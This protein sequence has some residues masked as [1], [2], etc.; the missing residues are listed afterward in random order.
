MPPA[1]K[2]EAARGLTLHLDDSAPWRLSWGEPDW[3]GP[4]GFMLQ[5]AGEWHGG[6][7]DVPGARHLQPSLHGFAGRDDLGAYHSVDVAWATLPIPLRTSVRAYVDAPVIVFRIEAPNGVRGLSTGR[8]EQPSVVWP[9]L[10]PARRQAG[11]VPADTVSCGH[12]YTEF[13]LPVSGDAQCTGFRFAPHRPPVVEPLLFIAPDGRTLLLAPLDQFHEQIIVVPPDRESASDGVRCGW[14]GD[15]AEVPAGFATELAIWAG[16]GPREVLDA[17]AALLR[18]RHGTQRATR[19]ADAGVGMLSYWT[20]NGSVYYY[21]TEPECDYLTTLERVV[22]DL[23]AHDVPVRSLQID[24]WFY[25]HENLREVSPAGAPVVPPSGMLKWEPRADLFPNGASDLQRRVG[26]LPLTFH[27]RHFSH[28]SP[29]FEQYAAW[30][31]GAYAHP[32]D[33]ALFDRLMAQAATWGAIT[34]EQ[35]WM[36]ESFFGV[37]GLRAAPGRV[38]AW[39]EQL[40]RAAGEHGL[41]LQWCMATPA[42]FFQTVTLRHLT[43]I[44]T[45]GDYRYLFDNGLN[46][47]WFLHT[48]ALARALGLHPFKDVFLS[49]GATAISPGEEYAEAEALLA[50]LSSGPVAIGDQRGHT[51]RDLVM[52]VCR[53]D[54]VLIKPDVP[55]AALNR[56]FRRN[57]F[58][59]SSP[60]IGEC[61]SQHP[62]GR[63]LYVATFNAWREKQPLQFEIELADLGSVRPDGAVIVYD[64][65]RR[66]LESTERNGGW[67]CTLEFQD[68]DYRVLCPLLPGGV[69]VFGDVAKYATAGDRRIAAITATSDGVRFDVLGAPESWV[70]V[71]GYAATR[72]RSFSAWVPGASRTIAA[73]DALA[74][75]SWCWDGDSGEWRLRICSGPLG[76]QRVSLVGDA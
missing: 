4:I 12:Q 15:L 57:S 52:R 55:L 32:V 50:A 67:D 33:G 70:D 17:W 44:R 21:R 36:V 26:G 42:D 41:T 66:T 69:T 31:D 51:N 71:H 5:R 73:A 30:S 20:D 27:S 8:F 28:Q 2:L 72:P 63:W 24:S 34:Y 45:S 7:I 37:R 14:H 53:E 22:T 59:E 10:Q 1:D 47:V 68:W 18:Q 76:R 29:Y 3:L 23:H 11:G 46:W 60:L 65:R 43:S 35:D 64:W 49:H 48:N 19:Y 75:E 40:D 13:A 38:R 54:G 9:I 58:F 6:G 74:G 25:P 61:Y 62:A 56:C 16:D 39:Q